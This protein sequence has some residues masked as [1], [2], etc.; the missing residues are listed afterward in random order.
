[1]KTSTKRSYRI[2]TVWAMVLTIIAITVFVTFEVGKIVD[3]PYPNNLGKGLMA[4]LKGVILSQAVLLIG[5][6]FLFMLRNS[7]HSEK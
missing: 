5:G 7:K 1:M 3:L 6:L 2:L 4:W